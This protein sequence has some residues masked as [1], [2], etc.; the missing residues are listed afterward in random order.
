MI[1]SIWFDKTLTYS[2]AIFENEKNN[3]EDAQ[4]NK[5]KKLSD[6]SKTKNWR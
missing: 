5:Y 1:F 2:S 3:L 6:L 4:I